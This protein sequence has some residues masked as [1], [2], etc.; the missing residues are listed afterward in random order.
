MPI[1]NFYIYSNCDFSVKTAAA[2]RMLHY[3]R[4]IAD[5]RNKVY[6]ISC[7]TNDLTLERFVEVSSNV[8]ILEKKELT[9]KFFASFSFLRKLHKFSKKTKGKSTFL[10]YPYPFFKLEFL[11][12]LYMILL[13]RHRVF[14]ELNEVKKFSSN[15]H[16]PLPP[17]K[18][19]KVVKRQY[20]KCRYVLMDYLMPFYS[21]LICISTNI[22]LYGKKYNKNTL[23]IPILT[24][25]E[26][27][28]EKAPKSYIN[29]DYFNIGFSGSIVPSKE[30][31]F[32]FIEVIKKANL[33]G[34]QIQFN[35]SGVVSPEDHKLLFNEANANLIKYYGKLDENQLANFL[36]QQ[37]LLVVPRGYTLQNK[38]GFSTK[39]SDYLN[40]KKMVLVTNISDTAL[41]I[42]DGVNGFMVEPDDMQMMFDKLIYIVENFKKIERKIVAN[43]L[44]TSED[45]FGYKVYRTSLRKFLIEE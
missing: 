9:R 15:F 28:F 26:L 35:L 42:K 3:A 41:Y 33:E 11:S 25:P 16:K 31:L 21:G 2:T 43:A 34:Y 38:Y 14:Y 27:T 19:K 45:K 32:G 40:H 1:Y 6:L 7:C 37:D 30:N 24:N 4:S 18:L 44:K 12:V 8:F 10:V 29:N 17:L 13:K 20:H 23:R 5:D 36:S 39:L 22:E